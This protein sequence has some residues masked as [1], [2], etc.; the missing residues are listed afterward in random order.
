MHID[1]TNEIIAGSA[2]VLVIIFAISA[3]FDIRERQR[4]P[5]SQASAPHVQE[6]SRNAD[7]TPDPVE[8]KRRNRLRRQLL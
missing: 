2:F 5:S 4:F 6:K 7:V 1:P 8:F 3:F